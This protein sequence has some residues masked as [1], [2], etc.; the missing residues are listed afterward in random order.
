MHF[1]KVIFSNKALSLALLLGS[2]QVVC[3]LAGSVTFFPIV[4]YGMYSQIEP[5]QKSYV[6]YELEINGQKLDAL[7]YRIHLWEALFNPLRIREKNRHCNDFEEDKN[8]MKKGFNSLNFNHLYPFLEPA[9]TNKIEKNSTFSHRY[10]IYLAHILKEPIFSM[11]VYESEYG[12]DYAR[13]FLIRK[14]L[15]VHE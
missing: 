10:K 14:T 8:L 13:Y 7:D 15:L 9:I 3:D 11:K 4:H 12:Y 2:V 6:T 1:L 5:R